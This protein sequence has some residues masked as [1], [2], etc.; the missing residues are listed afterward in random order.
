MKKRIIALLTCIALLSALFFVPEADAGNRKVN[1]TTQTQ[2]VEVGKSFNIK[3]NGIKA[4]KVKWSSSKSSIATVSK[5]GNV[6][7]IKSGNTTIVGKYKGLIFKIKVNVYDK[8]DGHYSDKEYSVDYQGSKLTKL[9]GEKVIALKYKYSNKTSTGK[10][11]NDYCLINVYVNDVEVECYNRDKYT[12]NVKNGAS[13]N[14]TFYYEAKSGDKIDIEMYSYDENYDKYYV[15][16]TS[17]I[18]K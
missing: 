14:V 15:H 13:I 8:S 7:G 10:T 12:T 16:Q 1:I 5:S 17:F 6:K 2:A 18:A 4:S 3:L 9:Y 11:L